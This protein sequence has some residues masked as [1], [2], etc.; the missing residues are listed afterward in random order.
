MFN[1]WTFGPPDRGVWKKGD[2]ADDAHYDI[3]K[4]AAEMDHLA[5]PHSGIVDGLSPQPEQPV[6]RKMSP[7]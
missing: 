5:T 1:G 3:A 7:P 6:D 4:G 2:K